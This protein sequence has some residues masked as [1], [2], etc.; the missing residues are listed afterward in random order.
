[1]NEYDDLFKFE[2]DDDDY[3]CKCPECKQLAADLRADWEY[4]RWH[5]R[6]F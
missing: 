6:D 3:E 1:M 5:D 4:D 2:H